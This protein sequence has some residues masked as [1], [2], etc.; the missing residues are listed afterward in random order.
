MDLKYINFSLSGL[1]YRAI[2]MGPVPTYTTACLNTWQD[3][4]L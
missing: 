4:T 2:Q 1:R 3:K